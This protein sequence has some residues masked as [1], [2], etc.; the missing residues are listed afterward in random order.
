MVFPLKIGLMSP[1]GNP[2]FVIGLAMDHDNGR[3]R[4]DQSIRDDGLLGASTRR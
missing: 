4:D 3:Y 1:T 2:S